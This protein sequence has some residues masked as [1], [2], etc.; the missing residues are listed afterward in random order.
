MLKYLK[1]SSHLGFPSKILYV[2]LTSPTRSKAT[3]WT[4]KVSNPSRFNKVFFT[5]SSRGVTGLKQSPIQWKPRL[6]FWVKTV[7]TGG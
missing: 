5:K 4:T 2:F 1:L 6:L 7:G 3:G